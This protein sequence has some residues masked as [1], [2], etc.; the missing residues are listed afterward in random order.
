[1]RRTLLA[2]CLCVA[3]LLSH[4]ATASALPPQGVYDGCAPGGDPAAGQG[5]SA[6]V[7]RLQQLRAEGFTIVLDYSSLYGSSDEVRQYAAAAASL[8]IKLIWPLHHP[9]LRAGTGAQAYL[10]LARECGCQSTAEL[11][12]YIVSVVKDLPATYMYYVG[13][14]VPNDQHA[15]V[16]QVSD[17]IHALDPA[18]PRFYVTFG[19]NVAGQSLSAFTD[20]ADVLGGDSYPIEVGGDPS[21]VAGDTRTTARIAAAAERPYAMVLQAFCFCQEGHTGARYPSRDDYRRMLGAAL[22]SGR[23]SFVLWWAYYRLLQSDDPA[24]RVNDFVSAVFGERWPPDTRMT[25]GGAGGFAIQ[26]S[27]PA[28]TTECRLDSA[29]WS[30]CTSP[31]RL[32]GLAPGAHVLRARARDTFGAVDP[33][34]AVRRFRV[35][36]LVS[37]RVVGR[38]GRAPTLLIDVRR[39]TRARLVVRRGRARFASTLT[40]RAGSTRHRLAATL[41]RRMAPG[42]WRLTVTAGR[43]ALSRSA[44]VTAAD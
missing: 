30:P 18:H 11:V 8:G 2:G 9:A 17:L 25:G 42:R 43:E 16:R 24:A 31:V 44:A 7:S 38:P 5:L 37:F 33:T 14:E 35:R 10:Q 19:S 22:T 26:T 27:E 4:N 23:P 15:G 36:N 34:P 39:A 28:D 21:T 32:D 40:L 20:T 12:R 29:P 41:A 1:L 13:D 6:C 3:A